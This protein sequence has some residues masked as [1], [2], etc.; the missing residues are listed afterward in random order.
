MKA[1]VLT[2]V[3][4]TILLIVL[5]GCSPSTNTCTS[6]SLVCADIRDNVESTLKITLGPYE[7]L[8]SDCRFPGVEQGKEITE[9]EIR[10]WQEESCKSENSWRIVKAEILERGDGAVE[11]S[12]P[13]PSEINNYFYAHQYFWSRFYFQH[14]QDQGIYSVSIF[15]PS[16]VPPE[17]RIEILSAISNEVIPILMKEK[18]NYG[19]PVTVEVEP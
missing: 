15:S 9:L 10:W 13:V 19:L 16:S 7:G 17:R 12:G 3:C 6:V 18:D 2:T 5:L 14:P 1:K 8:T 4:I 11:V